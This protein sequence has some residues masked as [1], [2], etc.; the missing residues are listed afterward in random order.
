MEFVTSQTISP[1]EAKEGQADS[2]SVPDYK[3]E[4]E[5]HRERNKLPKRLFPSTPSDKV[6]MES[7]REEVRSSKGGIIRKP[8]AGSELVIVG[9]GDQLT[10][11]GFK[12]SVKLLRSY[13]K[14][15]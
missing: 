8:I 10:P 6:Q 7:P 9:H 13:R 14:A 15:K 1:S 2:S 4:R 11:R 3:V 12:N 5:C